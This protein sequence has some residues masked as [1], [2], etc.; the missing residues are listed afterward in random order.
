MRADLILDH[1]VI[2]ASTNIGELV[3]LE[4]LHNY[5]QK[6]WESQEFRY[7]DLQE[8]EVIVRDSNKTR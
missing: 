2:Y 6:E 7:R 5:T 3:S 8:R 4:C 1:R